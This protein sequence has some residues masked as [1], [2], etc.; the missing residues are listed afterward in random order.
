MSEFKIIRR[1]VLTEMRLA[2]GST[3]HY[4]GSVLLSAPH[5]LRIGRYENSQGF[6]LIHYDQDG[7][8]MTDTYHDT[9]QEALNQA[10]YEFHVTPNE[11]DVLAD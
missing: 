11:W 3:K 8:E 10:E 7:D 6:Y 2:T 1:I 5:E 4:K 9:V